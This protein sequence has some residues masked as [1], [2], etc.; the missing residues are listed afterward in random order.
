MKNIDN[1]ARLPKMSELEMLVAI[2]DTGSFGGAAAELGCTQSRVS[3]AMAEL[4]SVLGYQLLQRSRTGTAP[5]PSGRRVIVEARKILLG[6]Q[7][8]LASKSR[9]LSGV[10]RVATY[11]SVATHL[12]LPVI[13]ALADRHPGL[14]IEVDDGCLEREDVERRVRDGSADLGIAHLPVGAGLSIRPFAE[15]DYVVVVAQSFTPSKRYFWQDLEELKFIELRCSGSAVIVAKCRANGMTS[16]PASSFSSTSTILANIKN[17]RSFS[18]LPRLSLEPLPAGLRVV[19]LPVTA[20]RSL[21]IILPKRQPAAK[22]RAVLETFRQLKRLRG[23]VAA[24]ARL[25]VMC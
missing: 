11:E 1:S 25:D 6:A 23:P 22:E 9:M 4:E 20:R 3:H 15:D 16:K 21:A 5:T 12:L 7:R 13:D 2:A 8:M 24:W 18:I 14:R 17:G 19:D 10:V